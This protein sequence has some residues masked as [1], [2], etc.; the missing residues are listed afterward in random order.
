MFKSL[1]ADALK[2]IPVHV[3]PFE[4]LRLTKELLRECGAVVRTHM[5]RC[6]YTKFAKQLEASSVARA[7]FRNDVDVA[8]IMSS[9]SDFAKKTY[10]CLL[11]KGLAGGSPK[12]CS[13]R[14]PGFVLLC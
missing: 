12:F 1:I 11:W 8:S 14:G 3:P 9:R 7:V 5:L 6:P 2:S 10:H 4:R 13:G